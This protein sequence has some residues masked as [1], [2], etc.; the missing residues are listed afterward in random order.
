M[1]TAAMIS[2]GPTVSHRQLN[3]FAEILIMVMLSLLFCMAFL[4][5]FISIRTRTRTRTIDED[6]TMN[7]IVDATT[8][9][10]DKTV[11]DSCPVFSYNLVEGLKARSKGSECAVCLSD[12]EDEEVL[13][14]LP[15]CSH[16]F[17]RECVDVWLGLHATCP[18]CRMS[19]LPEGR[20]NPTWT[21]HGVAE[22]WTRT[23]AERVMIVI[24]RIFHI[25]LKRVGFPYKNFSTTV[26]FQQDNEN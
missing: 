6:D 17:H 11:L 18:V 23:S 26:M 4:S 22:A 8:R 5:I 9:G 25:I 19:L 1:A 20:A 7:G 15:L 21:R 24:D 14:L 10:L 2:I 16:A 3:P 12:F 13:R